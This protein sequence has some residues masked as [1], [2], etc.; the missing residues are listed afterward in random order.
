METTS[1][2]KD[3]AILLTKLF[4]QC[5]ALGLANSQYEFSRLCGR[6]PSWFSSSRCRN[7]AISTDAAVTL[8]VKLEKS[9]RDD[10]N[11]ELQSQAT[12]LSNLLMA[13]VKERARA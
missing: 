8:S 9:A 2:Q 7:V 13:V 12:H 6:K 3:N 5:K 4:R 11:S 10:L 1:L